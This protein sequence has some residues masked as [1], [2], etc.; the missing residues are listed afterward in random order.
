MFEQSC[1]YALA[2]QTKVYHPS[3]GQQLPTHIDPDLYVENLK[4]II[5]SKRLMLK[6]KNRFDM[7]LCYED[8]HFPQDV[9]I[10]K[11]MPKSRAILNMQQLRNLYEANKA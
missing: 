5:K 4:Y 9:M 1:S 11:F 8:I 3:E 10:G 2:K 7:W 6:H